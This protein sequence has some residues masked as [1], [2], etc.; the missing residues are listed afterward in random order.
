MA[1]R[2]VIVT[3]AP[4]SNFQGKEANP[5]IPYTPEEIAEQVYGA[6]NA[7]AS[8]AHMHARDR[9]GRAGVLPR[10]AKMMAGRGLKPQMEIFTDFFKD[11]A[12]TEIYERSLPAALLF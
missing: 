5:A 2:K 12:P 1:D 8:L 9:C 3:V 4:S 6:W 7:G 10:R 11:A